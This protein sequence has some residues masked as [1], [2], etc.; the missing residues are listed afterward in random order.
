MTQLGYDRAGIIPHKTFAMVSD[1]ALAEFRRRVAR[2][3][4]PRSLAMDAF[5]APPG[6]CDVMSPALCDTI[7]LAQIIKQ[8]SA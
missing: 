4:R 6:A 2:G 3:E 8:L 7:L 1:N 5:D